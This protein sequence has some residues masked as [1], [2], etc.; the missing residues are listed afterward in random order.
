M[1][2]E[3]ENKEATLD[4]A[5]DNAELEEEKEEKTEEGKEVVEEVVE[6]VVKEVVKEEVVEE[7][8]E[9]IVDDKK[10]DAKKEPEPKEEVSRVDWESLG[11]DKFKG[12]TD[13]EVV[14]QI[15]ADRQN[16]G[17]TVNL[18]GDLRRENAEL[19]KQSAKEPVKEEKPKDILSSIPKLND[20][21]KAK[22]NAIY[23]ESPIEAIMTYGGDTIKL[24]VADAVKEAMPKGSVD[25]VKAEIAYSA[26][27]NTAKPNAIEL[28]QMEI[29]DEEKFLG[30]QAR[31]YDDLFELSKMWLA[32]ETGSKDIYDLMKKHPTISFS[33]AC[34]FVI[35]PEAEKVKV[36]KEKI[37]E[38]IN[39]NKK[40]DS[41]PKHVAQAMPSKDTSFDDAWDEA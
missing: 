38:T 14:E 18:L 21:D 28:E 17:H 27:I 23:E 37:K 25:D 2:T 39:K 10:E 24:M 41:H 40:A 35:K 22:F 15:K 11:F 3:E 7:V 6:E 34:S 1:L 8:V 12:K 4:E 13:Q 29:F 20:A 32:K 36:D 9:E 30:K 31:S 26:F 16:L 33:E 5:W 19:I